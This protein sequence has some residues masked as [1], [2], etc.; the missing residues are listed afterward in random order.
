[1]AKKPIDEDDYSKEEYQ[2]ALEIACTD[3]KGM[4]NVNKCMRYL[5][6]AE[7]EVRLSSS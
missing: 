6:Q 4:I 3:S 5:I 1:M 2:K 7:N